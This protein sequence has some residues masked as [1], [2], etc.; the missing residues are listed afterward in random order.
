MIYNR[1]LEN[2]TGDDKSTLTLKILTYMPKVNQNDGESS[3][4]EIGGGSLFQFTDWNFKVTYLS[5][6]NLPYHTCP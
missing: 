5:I 1:L 4:N 2:N 3:V 6:V